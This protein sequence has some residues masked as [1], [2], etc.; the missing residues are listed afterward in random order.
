MSYALT[1][2]PDFNSLFAT[3]YVRVKVDTQNVGVVADLGKV[4]KYECV[5]FTPA[6]DGFV[7]LIHNWATRGNSGSGRY[8]G[9][10]QHDADPGETVKVMVAGVG[11]ALITNRDTIGRDVS[12]TGSSPLALPT[13]ATGGNVAVVS[14]PLHKA[15]DGD[16]ACGELARGAAGILNGAEAT[17]LELVHIHPGYTA[18]QVDWGTALR[19]EM[20]NQYWRVGNATGGTLEV[21]KFYAIKATGFA[22]NQN[23]REIVG[24]STSSA[25]IDSNTHGLIG[26]ALLPVAAGEYTV[27]KVAGSGLA[28]AGATWAAADSGKPFEVD[29]TGRI[30]P[31]AGAQKPFGWAFV[32]Q[33]GAGATLTAGS[34]VRVWFQ[35]ISGV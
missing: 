26:M 1:A 4:R 19:P 8:Y 5:C 30:V 33:T 23:P 13:R 21:G 28:I 16:F 11:Y 24:I 15:I 6:E 22:N 34:Q 2:G 35:G 7:T 12:T 20:P 31:H 27:I 32:N 9:I 10:A 29:A 18:S 14:A 17:K 3:Q 25:S